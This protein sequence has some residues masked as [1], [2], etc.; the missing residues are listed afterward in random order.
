MGD[1]GKEIFLGRSATILA[2]IAAGD[3]IP[4]LSEDGASVKRVFSTMRVNGARYG[5]ELRVRN[6]TG[7]APETLS[8]Q[9]RLRGA[10][11]ANGDEAASVNLWATIKDTVA[12]TAAGVQ[13]TVDAGPLMHYV[14]VVSAGIT[15]AN[16]NGG[17]TI[18]VWLVGA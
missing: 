8:V 16:W 6:V 3:A 4:F 2:N 9:V 10:P 11:A 14:Q 17:A 12:L 5:I 18:E 7:S 15:A 13:L 1:L